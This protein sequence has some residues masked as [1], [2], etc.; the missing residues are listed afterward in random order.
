MP[1]IGI[2]PDGASLRLQT[3][4][5]GLLLV[6]PSAAPLGALDQDVT[7]LGERGRPTRRHH[8]RRVVLLDDQ[9]PDGGPRLKLL[10]LDDGELQTES[11]WEYL[12]KN[13]L[14]LSVLDDYDAIVNACC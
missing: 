14:S 7:P 6:A 2:D 1:L 10:P 8:C 13:Y 4:G 9:R 3:A 12:R 11:I 5:H